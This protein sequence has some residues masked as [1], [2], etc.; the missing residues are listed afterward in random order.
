MYRTELMEQILKSPEAQRIVQMISPVYGDAYTA[1]WLFQ[2]IGQEMDRIE[3][4]SDE[5]I[6]QTVPWTATWSLD[7]WEQNYGITQNRDLDIEKRRQRLLSKMRDRA[8]V[9]PRK[10]EYAIQAASLL[11]VQARVLENTG[12]N[13]FTVEVE[14]PVD[15]DDK[16]RIK[17]TIDRL[18]PAHLIY[19]FRKIMHISGQNRN[20]LDFVRLVIH[21][22]ASNWK[23]S[24]IKFNAA[25]N[26]DGSIR[27]DQ[28]VM[29]Q[30]TSRIRIRTAARN[31]NQIKP[32]MFFFSSFQNQNDIAV[33]STVRFRMKNENAVQPSEIRIHTRA[34]NHQDSSAWAVFNPNFFFDGEE[35][36]SGGKRFN[37]G[38]AEE[39]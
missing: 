29:P 8:P 30:N 11:E 9:N 23:R 22:R 39:M 31:E 28:Q 36:F 4:L 38:V 10:L 1:L 35:I 2:A 6:L 19:L 24:P 21:W 26:F 12:K 25:V 32:K 34:K 37:S 14:P 33:R 7:F 13:Q 3:T 27:W 16:R 17:E 5:Y 15:A 20:E 18:K